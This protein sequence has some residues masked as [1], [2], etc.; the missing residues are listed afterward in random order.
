[1]RDGPLKR[2]GPVVGGLQR[3]RNQPDRLSDRRKLDGTCVA[4]RLRGGRFRRLGGS[5][6]PVL[7]QI[8]GQP[9]AQHDQDRQCRAEDLPGALGDAFF[10]ALGFCPDGLLVACFDQ[11]AVLV[12]F[13]GAALDQT[14]RAVGVDGLVVAADQLALAAGIVELAVYLHH[15]RVGRDAVLII[16]EITV[17]FN[18]LSLVR[19]VGFHSRSLFDCQIVFGSSRHTVF[20]TMAV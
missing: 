16:V 17:L 19:F 6:C 3:R 20:L 10:A 14:V 11:N 7:G 8:E 2:R 9:D 18:D 4:C 5:P 13:I 1:M 12:E 15:A